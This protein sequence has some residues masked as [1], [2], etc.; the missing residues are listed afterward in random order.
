M[1]WVASDSNCYLGFRQGSFVNTLSRRGFGRAGGP[2]VYLDNTQTSASAPI[3][4]AAGNPLAG[5]T[6]ATV[7]VVATQI[8]TPSGEE[9]LIS[10]WGNGSSF[11]AEWDSS[12]QFLFAVA[13]SG[14]SN[15]E[16]RSAFNIANPGV[17]G[18]FVSTWNS[19]RTGADR[20]RFWANGQQ[21]ASNNSF[22]QGSVA[23]IS[24]DT[25]GNLNLG[26]DNNGGTN[27]LNSHLHAFLLYPGDIGDAEALRASR[28]PWYLWMPKPRR[29]YAYAVASTASFSGTPGLGSL[30][31]TGV[32]STL[33][34]GYKFAPTAG[35]LV[36]TGK[37]PTLTRAFKLAPGAGS[38][39]K[40]GQ[41][42]TLTRKF[43]FA[44]STGSL[45]KT[46]KIPTL[47]TGFKLQPAAGSIVKTGQTLTLSA[48]M[49]PATGS[50]V[51]TGQVPVLAIGVGSGALLHSW[52][53]KGIGIKTKIG[54][55]SQV[56]SDTGDTP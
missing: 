20:H 51:K 16:L 15:I 42:P 39:V 18:Y 46:G 13:D 31:K 44:P 43:N 17:T 4:G 7:V 21:F 28:S 9:R 8:N 48:S 1:A 2:S 24:T 5:A 54:V 35:S 55:H 11:F 25:S 22:V 3:T 37:I 50:I 56:D 23:S 6:A 49:S 53:I 41:I 40:T 27:A 38:L 19:N 33:K 36:K 52:F 10:H 34:I 29:F 45:V 26:C 47:A 14:A 30:V 12:G 32:V